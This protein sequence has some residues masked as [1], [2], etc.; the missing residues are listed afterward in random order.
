MI[1]P[2]DVLFV[3]TGVMNNTIPYTNYS[4]HLQACTDRGCTQSIDGVFIQVITFICPNKIFVNQVDYEFPS[5]CYTSNYFHHQLLST[6]NIICSSVVKADLAAFS[7]TY[8][9]I[10]TWSVMVLWLDPF[11]G[12]S[13]FLHSNYHPVYIHILIVLLLEPWPLVQEH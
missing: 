9:W 12:I 5:T 13:K 10:W 7:P 1:F 11:I 2:T 3:F 8:Q 4:I 6:S